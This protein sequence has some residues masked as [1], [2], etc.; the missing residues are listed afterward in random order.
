M[1][2]ECRDCDS[3]IHDFMR[4]Q[5]TDE[6]LRAKAFEHIMRCA[7]CEARF[8]N[9]RSLEKALRA[10][11]KTVDSEQSAAPL[12]PAL[13]IVFQQQKGAKPRSRSFASWVAIGMA[14]SMLLSIGFVSRH[15]L[16]GPV[17][18]PPMVATPGQVPPAIASNVQIPE[19]VATL[20][21]K[22]RKHSKPKTR[23]AAQRRDTGEFVTAFYALPYAESFD[24]T[25]SGEVVRVK[26]R[27]SALPGIGFPMALNGD[28]ASEQITADLIVGENGLPLAIRFVR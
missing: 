26:L 27:G 25:M 21:P 7:R 1:T 3:I 14:A 17:R 12:E 8:S 28:R 16:F 22:T 6:G 23:V 11:A 10:L 24:H 4:P 13:R 9:I 2:M 20:A 18:K 15:R 19:P 5:V